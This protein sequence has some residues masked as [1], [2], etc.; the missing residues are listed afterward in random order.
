MR[1]CGEVG[2]ESYRCRR[3][4][5]HDQRWI[6][7]DGVVKTLIVGLGGLNFRLRR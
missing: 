5:S 3:L 1:L 4:G 6:E 7:M 2:E